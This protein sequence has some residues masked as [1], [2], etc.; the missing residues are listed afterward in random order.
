MPVGNFN[1]AA[2][3]MEQSQ[4]DD[5]LES[6]KRRDNVHRQRYQK[7]VLRQ[8]EREFKLIKCCVENKKVVDNFIRK[9]LDVYKANAQRS[10]RR[11]GIDIKEVMQFQ[12]FLLMLENLEEL[13]YLTEHD[14]DAK[15]ERLKATEHVYKQQEA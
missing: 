10:L 9:V 14:A 4:A 2:N 6:E 7:K 5:R 15:E 8:L 3:I 13:I 1:K 12:G 11:D